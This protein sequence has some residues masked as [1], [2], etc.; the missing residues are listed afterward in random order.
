[1]KRILAQERET[2]IRHDATGED[3][4]VGSSIPG[5]VARLTKL[6]GPAPDIRGDWHRWTVPKRTVHLPRPARKRAPATE[7]QKAAG[8]KLAALRRALE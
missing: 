8:R 7:A 5:D 3:A 2:I 4:V 6:W 1:M